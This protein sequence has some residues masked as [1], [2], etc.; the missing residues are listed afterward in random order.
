M[1]TTNRHWSF[2]TSKKNK[3]MWYI[4]SPVNTFKCYSLIIFHSSELLNIGTRSLSQVKL[5]KWISQ[6]C[7]WIIHTG[8]MNWINT[9][10]LDQKSLPMKEPQR[11][12]FCFKKSYF[13]A[14][15]Y[16][17]WLIFSVS[18]KAWKNLYHFEATRN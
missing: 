13:T 8:F 1:I 3:F 14:S 7:E 11:A 4:A 18:F 6:I 5:K 10:L 9:L 15:E 17:T 16:S 2:Q 12:N